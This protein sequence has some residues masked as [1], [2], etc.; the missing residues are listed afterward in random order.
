MKNVLVY[1]GPMCAFCDA[2]KKLL[3]RNNISYKE[4]NIA[5]E[6]N[7]MDEMISKSNGKRTIPQIFFDDH[8]VGGYE[9]LRALEKEK[10]L[11]SLLK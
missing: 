6:E 2:A 4:I 3:V 1:M 11:E 8:H 9:E 7:K 10:K 5:L